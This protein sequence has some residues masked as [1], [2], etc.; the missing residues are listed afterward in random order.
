MN[1]GGL[2]NLEKRSP[3][4]IV[5]AAWLVALLGAG[6]LVARLWSQSIESMDFRYVW[7]AGDLWARNL[8]PYGPDYIAAGAQSFPT[9]YR[10]AV[11]AYP[12]HWYLPARVAA[13]WPPPQAF[14]LWLAATTTALAGAGRLVLA[15]AR[16][17]GATPRFPAILFGIGFAASSS[18]VN[19]GL[20]EGQ[21]AILAEC[22]IALCLFGVAR[23]QRWWGAC[24]LMVAML[25]P[26]LGLPFATA[27]C[28]MPGGWATVALAVA[29]TLIA[30]VPA[31]LASGATEQ[32]HGLLVL[33]RGSYQQVSVN[34]A[35]MMSG[36]PHLI[37]RAT[38]WSMSITVS[39][40]I[41][42][43]ATAGA[44]F[45]LRYRSVRERTLLFIG[46]TCAITAALIGLHPY[47]LIIILFTLPLLG[48]L[49]LGARWT[50]IAGF[51]LLWR[52][53]SLS[54]LLPGEVNFIPTI[55]SA[56]VFMILAA[57]LLRAARGEGAD[58]PITTSESNL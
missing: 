42:A 36:L 28:F 4:V 20:R 31:L 1:L 48:E 46:L 53:P 24:G 25:K 2:A 51:V 18:A 39:M 11:W 9:G 44:M 12:F 54:S 21:P 6:Y 10:I 58:R 13:F 37:E 52:A 43:V 29:G 34:T 40:L 41:A 16:A 49:P 17:I 38:S 55:E 57:W 8:N 7:L 27:L 47:D 45:L 22:G 30:C 32:V 56:A 23:G 33:S 50:A 3:T 5:T 19:F 15:A 14:A 35:D 26:H